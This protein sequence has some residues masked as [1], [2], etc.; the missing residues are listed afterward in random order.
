MRKLLFA[1]LALAPMMLHAQAILPAQ[2]QAAK[3]VLMAKL[4][5]SEVS[6]AAAHASS[7][8]RVSTGVTAAKLVV[9]TPVQQTS[10]WTWAPTETEKVA[11]VQLTVQPD[12]TPSNLSMVNSLGASIDHDVLASVATYRFS[13]AKLDNESVPLDVNLTVRI[14]RQ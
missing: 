5:A 13:P 12:G 10:G 2:P 9:S 8:L 4:N 7:P 11:V 1:S 14:H 3:S 6:G